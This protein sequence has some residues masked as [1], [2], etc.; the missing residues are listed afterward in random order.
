MFTNNVTDSTCYKLGNRISS[1][2]MYISNYLLGDEPVPCEWWLL[3]PVNVGYNTYLFHMYIKGSDLIERDS[4][5]YYRLSNT[6]ARRN[7]IDRDIYQ[8]YLL[9][10]EYE[11]PFILVE[12]NNSYI[13]NKR[14]YQVV[15]GC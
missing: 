15:C 12:G 9:D 4:R 8:D 7:D 1:T 3:N 11:I 2:S 6:L 5:L 14:C 10:Y 13:G